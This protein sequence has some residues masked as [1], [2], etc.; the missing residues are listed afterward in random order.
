MPRSYPPW[1]PLTIIVSAIVIVVLVRWVWAPRRRVANLR[2]AA[3]RLGLKLERE[4]LLGFIPL[5]GAS[6]QIQGR[7][8]WFWRFSKGS[9]K[10]RTQYCA[11]CVRPKE[12]GVEFRL[13]P[14]GFL[15]G[16]N[17]LLGTKEITVGDAVF[18]RAWFVETDRAEFFRAALGPDIRAGL[19]AAQAACRGGRFEGEAGRV[20]YVERGTFL[21][22][23]QVARMVENVPLLLDLASIVEVSAER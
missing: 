10:S 20:F 22:A 4:T 11:V 21:N 9:G 13:T 3:E 1:L 16:L 23:A 5:A 18:D 2:R 17:A 12:H 19:M 15:T 14:Q 8:V 6:G 7:D